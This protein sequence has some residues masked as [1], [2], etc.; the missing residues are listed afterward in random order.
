MILLFVVYKVVLG[1]RGARI[2]NTA[3]YHH[4]SHLLLLIV[5]PLCFSCGRR[6]S[7]A[8]AAAEQDEPAAPAAMKF[9]MLIREADDQLAAAKQEQARASTICRSSSC[10]ATPAAPRRASFCIP[11]STP[12]CWPD[13]SIRTIS[14]AHAHRQLWFTRRTLFVEAGGKLPAESSKWKQV[15]RKLAA[16]QLR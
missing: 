11:V 8:Q 10:W 1:R 4:R 15:V 7:Q 2:M 5:L 12:N 16:P 6:T 9:R 14:G 13:R 3:L